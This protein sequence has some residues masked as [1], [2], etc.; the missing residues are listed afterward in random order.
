ML[1]TPDINDENLYQSSRNAGTGSLLKRVFRNDEIK[2]CVVGVSLPIDQ[3]LLNPLN[4]RAI[5]LSE[6]KKME[7]R[8]YVV[9][10][11]YLNKKP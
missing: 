8:P 11:E 7:V 6:L 5:Q 4:K 10:G 3:N 2:Y 9:P 1:K